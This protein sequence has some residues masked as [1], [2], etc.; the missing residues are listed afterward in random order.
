MFNSYGIYNYF[1]QNS[2]SIINE[3]L[4]N[5]DNPPLLEDLLIEEDIIDELQN[6]NFKLINYLNKEKMKQ[7]L[8]Y[9]I[10]EPK[11]ADHN[12]A[13]KFPFVVSKLFNVEETNIMKYFFKTNK[14]LKEENKE[15]N[16]LDKINDIYFD[17]NQGDENNDIKDKEINIDDINVISNDVDNADNCN[18][19]YDELNK[20]NKDYENNDDE[21]NLEENKGNENNDDKVNLEENKDNKDN[22][23][24]VNLENNN[25]ENEVNNKNDNEEE[26]KEKKENDKKNNKEGE[27]EEINKVEEIKNTNNTEKN[28][29]NN[30]NSDICLFK[31]SYMN[32][33]NKISKNQR[34]EKSQIKEKKENKNEEII[35]K[36]ETDDKYPED[37]IEILD[38]FFS[39]LIDDSELNYVLCGYFSS[40]MSNLLNIDSIKIIKYLFLERKDILKRL[41]YHSYRKSISE[42]LCK[43]IKY[44]D[45]FNQQNTEIKEDY[46]E[47][48][49]S[50]IRLDIIKDIFD[51]ID[52]NMDSEKL[53]SISYIINDLS[54]NKKIL[55]SI[56][57]DKN[58]IHSS[59]IYDSNK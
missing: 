28:E 24:E 27:K 40:L 15:K 54:E 51:K 13:Y 39:F 52:I 49:F 34:Y 20:E 22:N 58:S 30:N 55:E 53:Y 25:K 8:D 17:L 47:K 4:S 33:N 14:E 56:L 1:N 9:I 46:D 5:N 7:M 10:K 18:Y 29:Q 42:T 35:Q 59:F 37:K 19:N 44:E 50:K 2:N 23:Y 21:V 45:K 41:V 3:K 6:K 57:N 26:N 36:L 38:Y 31:S 16:N 32:E 11:D 48:E 12:K 43:I